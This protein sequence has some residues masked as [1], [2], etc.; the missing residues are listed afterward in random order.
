MSEGA[1]PGQDETIAV[2]GGSFDP[3]HV[4]HTLAAAYV[5]CAYPVTKLLAVPTAQHPFDKRLTAFGHRMRMCEL[6]MAP[7]MNV[8]VTDLEQRLG[9]ESL[10]LRTLEALQAEHPQAKLRLVLGTDLLADTPQWHNFAA[11]E[12]LAPPIVVQRAG[13]ETDPS[14]PCLPLV[15]STNVRERVREGRGTEG[16]LSPSVR[17]YVQANGLYLKR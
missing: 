11:V 14:Q 7:L 16:L 6:A 13:F 12:R 4:G 8:E 17:A 1:Q 9:G 5:L 3:P 10:T 2:F 15:S